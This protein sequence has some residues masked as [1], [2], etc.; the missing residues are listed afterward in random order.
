MAG[1]QADVNTRAVY[2]A[3]LLMVGTALGGIGGLTVLWL[4]WCRR[5][6]RLSAASGRL[7]V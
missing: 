7:R 5:V 3:V 2:D 6:T 4:L 1:G